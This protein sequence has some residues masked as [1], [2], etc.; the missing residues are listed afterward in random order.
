MSSKTTQEELP[1][2][3][4]FVVAKRTANLIFGEAES[5]LKDAWEFLRAEGGDA[6]LEA[7]SSA[8]NRVRVIRQILARD[9]MKVAFFG[10]TS[11]GKSSVVN[12][13]LG[14]SLLPSG[15]GHTTSCFVGLRGTE[16]ETP[17][18]LA[19]DCPE[20]RNV[21]DL[22]QLARAVS[23][24][25]LG[26]DALLRVFWPASRCPVLAHPVAFLDSPGVDVDVDLDGWIE[27]H[28]LDAD[29]FVLVVNAESTLN[30]SVSLF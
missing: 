13:L 22:K 12:A 29:V 19:P 8:A 30:C 18:V 15:I 9:A 17:F 1:H 25:K 4:K 26:P 6:A 27:R 28:C 3:A 5:L 20:K 7:V 11:N 10:R 14:D 16:E 23:D 24:T 21:E 2:L